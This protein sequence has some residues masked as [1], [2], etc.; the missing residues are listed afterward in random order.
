MIILILSSAQAADEGVR[1]YINVERE[2]AGREKLDAPVGPGMPAMIDEDAQEKRRQEKEAKRAARRERETALHEAKLEA[3]RKSEASAAMLRVEAKRAAMEKLGQAYVGQ[4]KAIRLNDLVR[5]VLGTTETK[6]H[7]PITT[8]PKMD[9]IAWLLNKNEHE[10]S[11]KYEHFLA[12]EMNARLAGSGNTDEKGMT[13]TEIDQVMAPYR[14][15][16][17]GT[18]ARNEWDR[19]APASHTGKSA[20]TDKNDKPGTLLMDLDR[21]TIEYY[22]SFADDIPSDILDELKTFIDKN[23]P[24]RQYL[25]LKVN[26]VVDQDANSINCGWFCSNSS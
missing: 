9:K 14:P 19:L 23:N 8:L 6:V 11:L 17:L 5:K 12:E 15:H 4:E 1:N 2:R 22:N 18:I 3:E 24:T 21:H 7:G 16:Y 20:W 26:R 10:V 25:K 13:T